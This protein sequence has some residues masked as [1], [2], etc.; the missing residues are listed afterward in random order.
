M[1]AHPSLEPLVRLDQTKAFLYIAR[2]ESLGP[3]CPIAANGSLKM[4]AISINQ[5]LSSLSGRGAWTGGRDSCTAR[6]I[7]SDGYWAFGKDW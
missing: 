2:P 4:Y 5:P 1:G 3:A 6:R 7:W